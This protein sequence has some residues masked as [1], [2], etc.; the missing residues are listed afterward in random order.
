[1]KKVLL[2][3]ITGF[4]GS[5]TARQ[6]CDDYEITAIIR[7][8]TPLHRYSEFVE[9]TEIVFI[10]LSDEESLAKFLDNR[11]FDYILHL[12]ALRGGRKFDKSEFEK[13][14]I[15]A[16]QLLMKNAIKNNSKF[17]FC[18]S[19]GVYGAIPL[20]LPATLST[21]Y[22]YDN[23]Y[24]TTKIECEKMIKKSIAE[25]KL[26]A[27]IVRPAITYGDGDTG[28]SYTLNKLVFKG[29]MVLPKERIRIHLLNINTLVEVFA[30]LLDNGFINS[31]IWNVADK[32][33][34]CL[35]DLVDF[36]SGE[37]KKYTTIPKFIFKIL[38]NLFKLVKNELW[39]SRLELISNSW[40]FD[41][42]DVYKDFNINNRSTIPHIKKR[43]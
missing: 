38:I 16:T 28:F 19:V 14:N 1:M 36:I 8:N 12:G 9:K 30:K 7:P 37:E 39:V 11:I 26:Q 29:I 34:T 18:S 15:N 31:K 20:E 5:K 4:I 43:G 23:I 13:T 33:P 3:G 25:S 24:H 42:N 2:T 10:S 41:V 21:P 27:C 6:I 35:Q 17:I 22:K 32:E 40:H